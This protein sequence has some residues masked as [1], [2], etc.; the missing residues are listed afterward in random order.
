MQ[1]SPAPDAL[2]QALD[3]FNTIQQE[4][5]YQQA[6]R[7]L[8]R[9]LQSSALSP[10]ERLGLEQD[11]ERLSQ[12]LEKLEQSRLHIAAFG[13]VGRGKSSALNALAG[14]TAF[15][16]GPTHGVTQT[17]GATT[18]AA[19]TQILAGWGRGEVQLLDTPGLD[20]VGGEER[21]RLAQSAAEA[22]DLILFIAAGDLC[23][24]EYDALSQ[25]RQAGKPMVLAI[26]KIDQYPPA[27]RQAIYEKIRDE[28]VKDLLSPEEIVLIAASP[29]ITEV[30]QSAD[31]K[32]QRRVYRGD[33]QIAPL[34]LRIFELLEREGKS[35]VALNALLGADQINAAVVARKLALRERLADEVIQKAMLVKAAAV[36]LNP[37]SAL[38]LFSGAVIDVA[39]ILSL[40]RLYELPLTQPAAVALLRQIGLSMGGVGASE[41]LASLGLSS[42]KGLLGLTVPVTGGL[43]LA[44]YTAAALTQGSVAGVSSYAIGQIAKTYL[45]QGAVWGPEGPKQ[46]AK[47]ILRSLD[48]ASVLARLRSELAAKI[49]FPGPPG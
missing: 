20:E 47:A 43:T 17:V 38:D 23:Q 9:V 19:P 48:E 10:R 3:A 24:L 36:A 2:D 11:L 1:D 35:L 15:E 46:S 12:L 34:R 45:A 13:L 26:N 41:F 5:N 7:S 30:R 44:P 28:R 4:L 8:R 39:L 18:W 6:Q 25:L 31:G 37:V 29:L 22:A 27:D 21:A 14:T 40:A 16:T 42:A 32:L 49:R 33:P